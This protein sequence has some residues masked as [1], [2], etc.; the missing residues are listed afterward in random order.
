MP[1]RISFDSVY[2]F[3]FA[4]FGMFSA[5]LSLEVPSRALE[6]N[7]R[8]LFRN[9]DFSHLI[10]AASSFLTSARI[11]DGSTS[12]SSQRNLLF[13][14]LFIL[15]V[16]QKSYFRSSN[17]KYSLIRFRTIKEMQFLIKYWFY[18]MILILFNRMKLLKF[19]TPCTPIN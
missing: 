18:S 14:N 9:I 3:A 16:F 2:A 11:F 7:T 13:N 8:T 12:V 10:Y 4:D 19:I 6:G 15:E 1:S 5:L 17:F